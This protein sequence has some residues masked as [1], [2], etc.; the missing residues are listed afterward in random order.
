[1]KEGVLRLIMPKVE[2]DRSEGRLNGPVSLK[3]P[4]EGRVLNPPLPCFFMPSLMATTG[5][6]IKTMKE[7]FLS[8]QSLTGGDPG[9]KA[10]ATL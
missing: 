6:P 5:R 10:F 8:P 4:R 1:M 3:K 9:W 2:K 7:Y